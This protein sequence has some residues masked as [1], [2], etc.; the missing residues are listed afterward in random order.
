[1]VR[2]Q[3]TVRLGGVALNSLQAR[4][5]T[6]A[7]A[8]HADIQPPEAEVF[9]TAVG[10]SINIL[11]SGQFCGIWDRDWSLHAWLVVTITG[12][13]ARLQSTPFELAV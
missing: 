13:S 1:M 3:Q 11:A 2:T 10:K 7:E 9:A 6:Q 12:V 4:A 5:T 8:N